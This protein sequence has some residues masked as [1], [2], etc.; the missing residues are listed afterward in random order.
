MMNSS[1]LFCVV[2]FD[3]VAPKAVIGF[4]FTHKSHTINKQ[5]LNVRERMQCQ[6]CEGEVD[7]RE[8]ETKRESGG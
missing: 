3:D 6:R 2:F 5:M 1:V 8:K 4:N 7:M